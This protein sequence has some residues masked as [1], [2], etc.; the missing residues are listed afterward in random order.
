[1]LLQLSSLAGSLVVPLM[2]HGTLARWT[3]ALIPVLG[4]AA[5]TGLITVPRLFLGWVVAFGLSSGASLSMSFSLF[6]LRARTSDAAGR[7]SGM[8]QSGGYAIAAAGPVAFGGL[9]S[10]TGGWLVPLLLVELTL[11]AQLAVGFFVGRER[12]VLAHSPST[13]GQSSVDDI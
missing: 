6:G 7:L 11:A 9:L 3:P 2:L 12:L 5:I 13:R 4:L 8:A 10:L 1:M